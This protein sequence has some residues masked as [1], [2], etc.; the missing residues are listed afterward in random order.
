MP[1]SLEVR[2]AAL[3]A[4]SRVYSGTGLEISAWSVMQQ[5]KRFETYIKTGKNADE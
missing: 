4:A 2:I 3:E 1:T 5:A